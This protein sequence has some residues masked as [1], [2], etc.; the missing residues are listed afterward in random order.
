[1]LQ[2]EKLGLFLSKPVSILLVVIYLLQ[3]GLLIYLITD[4]FDLEKQI[5]FQQKRIDELEE[6]L[7]A[8]GLLD[9][10][11]HPAVEI[12]PEADAYALWNWIYIAHEDKSV[13]VH[14]PA[15]TKALLEAS[16]AALGAE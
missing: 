2:F 10:E 13:G 16:L 6:K 1:M 4:K 7:L 14:N 9:E 12:M 11:G 8:K 3:S 5:R 15:Y